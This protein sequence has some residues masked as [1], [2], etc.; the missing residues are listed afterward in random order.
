MGMKQFFLV[1]ML[2]YLKYFIKNKLINVW[3]I[4]GNFYS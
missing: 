4:H 2:Y 3:E 1:F